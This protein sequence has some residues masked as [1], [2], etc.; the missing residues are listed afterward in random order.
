[1]RGANGGDARLDRHVDL[2]VRDV[3][4]AL[5]PLPLAGVLVT[6]VHREGRL[7]GTDLALMRELASTRRLPL[8]VAGG[9]GTIEELRTLP[10]S[11]S[12]P[13]SWAWRS[14]PARSKRRALAEEFVP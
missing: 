3:F 11:A 7:A 9:I 12:T 6:A 8:T 2:D 4:H 14:T 13:R 1:V 5:D 10:T